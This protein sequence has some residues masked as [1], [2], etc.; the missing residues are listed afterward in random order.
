MCKMCTENEA[1]WQEARTHLLTF[2]D[3]LEYLSKTL[4]GDCGK[5]YEYTPEE[6]FAY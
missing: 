3:K 1:D 5:E 6:V 4:C 2:A